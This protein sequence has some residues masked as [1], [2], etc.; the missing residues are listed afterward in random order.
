MIFC[1][2]CAQI[3]P[4]TGGK[5]DILPPKLI[6]AI[7]NNASTNFISNKIEL[8]FDEYVSLK[9]LSN[10]LIIT[11]QTNQLPDIQAV[12]KSIKILFNEALL[13]NTTYKLS[14]GNSIVDMRESNPLSNFEY[15]F[16]TGNNI[17]SLSINGRIENA[18]TNKSAENILVGLYPSNSSDSIIYNEKPLYI[19]KTNSSGN[20]SFNY[21]SNKN[22]K[23]IGIKD[24]NKNLLYDGSAEEICFWKKDVSGIDTS[25]ITMK[26]F[27]EERNKQFLKKSYSNEYGKAVFIYN[28]EIDGLKKV[29]ANGLVSYTENKGKD[30]LTVYYN[31]IFDTL[32]VIVEYNS[33]PNDTLLLKIQSSSEFEKNKVNGRFKYTLKPNF[34]TNVAY[35]TPLSFD[36][37]F[38][39]DQNTI[40]FN[41]I[42]FLETKDSV[43]SKMDF[44]LTKSKTN[45]VKYNLETN[46]KEDAQYSIMFDKAAFTDKYGRTN[47]SIRYDFKTT[48][49]EDYGILNLKISFPKKE[50]Y[51]ISLFNEKGEE[52]IAEKV[53]LALTSSSDQLISFKNLKPGNYF[54]K[55]VEDA[56]KNNHFDTGDYFLKKQPEIIFISTSSIKILSGWE[57][58]NEW[59]V[60]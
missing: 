42:L 57:I 33:K 5:K 43:K 1:T 52:T 41:K 44:K 2:Q 60:K 56:N 26:L 7:P 59:I 50:N 21:L 53:E 58:E 34:S 32:K 18:L 6:E 38:P 35:F 47:D 54:F 39:L 40:N 48:S 11:P 9:D 25:L 46:L 13:P 36:F 22:Y 15:V 12:G 17:D 20:F 37:N 45:E 31:T 55:A 19:S 23:I 14:F 28:K 27:K 49:S 24:D 29:S 30:S 8:K 4:L 51:L 10:Q 16:S 3:T